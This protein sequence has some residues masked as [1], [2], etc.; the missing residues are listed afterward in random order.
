[1]DLG[2]G[3]HATVD[4]YQILAYRSRQLR[5]V[6]RG[7]AAQV[8]C[9]ELQ[10][11]F[12]KFGSHYINRD[13]Y[14]DVHPPLG[15]MLVGLAGLLSGYNGGFEFKSG[16][17]YPSDLPYTSMRV[18]L[19]SF[20]VA[21]VPIAWFTAGEMGWSRFTR[22]WVTVCVLC[23]EYISSARLMTR[24]RLALHISVHPS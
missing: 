8:D 20:G 2:R 9:A 18:M 23:G 4:D 15:K 7:E 3:L 11:H 22:H 24:Y 1:M 6:G 14:F 17:E 12:G 13:F 21:L 19:A 10:A 5:R 16:V